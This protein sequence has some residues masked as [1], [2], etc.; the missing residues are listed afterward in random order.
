MEK[1]R[2][3]IIIIFA[4]KITQIYRIA[5]TVKIV[6]HNKTSLF[7]FEGKHTTI[8]PKQITKC[9]LNI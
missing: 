1:N 9:K 3:A 5:R 7:D 4:F 6:E 2:N 8:K